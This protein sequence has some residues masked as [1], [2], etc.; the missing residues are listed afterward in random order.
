M[1]LNICSHSLEAEY[2][3][4]NKKDEDEER[5]CCL[6]QTVSNMHGI[7]K[8]KRFEQQNTFCGVNNGISFVSRDSAVEP[9]AARMSASHT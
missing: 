2:Y 8:N 9:V 3:R 5:Q 4:I 1:K 6:L 7:I